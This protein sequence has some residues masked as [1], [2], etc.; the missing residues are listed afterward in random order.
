MVPYLNKSE[1]EIKDFM[2]SK[3]VRPKI[4]NFVQEIVLGGKWHK[5]NQHPP[6]WEATILPLTRADIGVDKFASP[7][8]DD[9]EY[10]NYEEMVAYVVVQIRKYGFD[11]K[12]GPFHRSGVPVGLRN[13][14]AYRLFQL[15]KTQTMLQMS[16]ASKGLSKKQNAEANVRSKSAAR[17]ANAAGLLADFH[18]GI[19]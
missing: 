15:A 10:F 19:H 3:Y 17:R 18:S 1:Q 11:K 8:G 2:V 12:S 6:G 13:G 9:I 5:V 4:V 16:S 14:R 7:E